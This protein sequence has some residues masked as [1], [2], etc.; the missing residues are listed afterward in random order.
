LARLQDGAGS[1][2][3][4]RKWRLNLFTTY[5]FDQASKLKG[6]SIG[7]GA[8]WQDKA[9]IGYPMI[10]DN[11]LN[12]HRPDI[13]NAH[14]GPSEMNMDSFVRYKTRILG[15]KVD[16]TLTLNIR[17]LMDEDD[18]IPVGANPNKGSTGL[19]PVWRIP[20]ERTYSLSARFNF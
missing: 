9:A 14:F 17:N 20:A 11:E 5:R 1:V 18:L 12:D 3:Q 16:M 10:F 13:N 7:G 8:R 6:W 2:D 15:D 19:I 4:I